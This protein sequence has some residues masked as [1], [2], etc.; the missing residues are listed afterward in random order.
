MAE[1]TIFEFGGDD[2]KSKFLC[3]NPE[4]WFDYETTDA[5]LGADEKIKHGDFFLATNKFGVRQLVRVWDMT[6]DGKVGEGLTLDAAKTGKFVLNDITQMTKDLAFA[7]SDAP[8]KGFPATILDADGTNTG[9][10]NTLKRVKMQQV[11]KYDI[12]PM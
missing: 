11:Y 2:D 4:V 8:A 9:E 3:A 10:A 1:D 6:D 7:W 5:P 12:M